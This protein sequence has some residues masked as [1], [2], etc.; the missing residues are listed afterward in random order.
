MKHGTA[1]VCLVAAVSVAPAVARALTRDDVIS[2]AEAGVSGEVLREEIRRSGQRFTT[3]DA[4]RE[5]LRTASVSERVNGALQGKKPEDIKAEANA[6]RDAEKAAEEERKRA[7][8]EAKAR[9]AAAQ[10]ERERL[11]REA[12]ELGGE[13]EL[14]GRARDV[15]GLIEQGYGQL[16]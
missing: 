2:L 3:S 1:L 10:A 15:D 4:D 14:E 9:E 6:R 7:A 5:R 8:Q 11:A 13:P 16:D 12:S